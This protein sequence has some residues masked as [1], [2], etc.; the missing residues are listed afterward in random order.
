MDTTYYELRSEPD[1]R[2]LWGDELSEQL[3]Y[4]T[5][6]IDDIATMKNAHEEAWPE[7]EFIVYRVTRRQVHIL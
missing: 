1:E 3:W 2:K 4:T 6:D 7:R 5:D